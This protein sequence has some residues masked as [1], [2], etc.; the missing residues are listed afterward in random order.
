MPP[1]TSFPTKSSRRNDATLVIAV[2]KDPVFRN[3]VGSVGRPRDCLTIPYYVNNE[4]RVANRASPHWPVFRRCGEI[5]AADH[6][7]APSS[8]P[9]GSPAAPISTVREVF[10]RPACHR[11]RQR[12]KPAATG[13]H[14]R[15]TV[16]TSILCP[17][18]HL[19]MAAPRRASASTPATSS[20]RD[21]LRRL[22]RCRGSR[23]TRVVGE[24]TPDTLRPPTRLPCSRPREVEALRC[25]RP[26]DRPPAD[27]LDEKGK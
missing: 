26:A 18:H 19:A 11:S 6:P 20:S 14:Q 24:S 16:R 3:L 15:P 10:A 17:R 5:P 22:R 2:G 21:R 27:Q 1:R 7:Q 23:S 12:F 25:G 4:S 9:T 13:R 8:A